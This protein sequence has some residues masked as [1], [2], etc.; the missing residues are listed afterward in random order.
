MMALCVAVALA[1]KPFTAPHDVNASVDL[2]AAI[3]LEANIWKTKI[4][5]AASRTKDASLLLQIAQC[6]E[7]IRNQISQNCDQSVARALTQTLLVREGDIK[8]YW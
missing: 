7:R 6:C 4:H 5:P 3:K 8:R 1:F 2:E